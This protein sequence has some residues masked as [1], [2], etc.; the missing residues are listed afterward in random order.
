MDFGLATALSPEEYRY[1]SEVQ[2]PESPTPPNL[3]HIIQQLHASLD[4]RTVFACYGKVLGQYLPI[5]GIRLTK[6]D[7]TL[8]WGRRYGI[9][10]TRQLMHG[11][12]ALCL[13]YQLI[14]PLTPSQVAT[15]QELEPL[16]L[17]PLLNALQYQEMSMQ[18]MF[19]SLTG[20]GNRHY[21]SKSIVHA[22]AT[23]HRKQGVISLVVLDLDHFKQLN[24]KF[25]HKCGDYILRAFGDIIRGN[26]R[27]TD[28]A[29]RIGGDE[30]VIIVQGSIEAAGLLCQRIVSAVNQHNSFSQFGVSCS[31]GAAEASAC[32][33]AEQLYELADNALYQAKA[34]GRNGFTLQPLRPNVA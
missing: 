33:P 32:L 28:Q 24:D 34:A 15:L 14:S 1:Q 25:G 12:K 19:D 6:D 11:A 10:L 26:I 27:S 3:V 30:F 13:Q 31:L 18:A 4:P 16:L 29:F 21:Y 5:Q 17:Q 2:W 8:N 23:A 7:Y 20:L 22:I 9:G